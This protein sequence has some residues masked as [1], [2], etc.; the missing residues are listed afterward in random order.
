[1]PKL[2][3]PAIYDDAHHVESYWAA[4]AGPEVP[5]WAPL[6]GDHACDVAVVG[7]GY[8]GLACALHLARD[9]GIDARV[10]EAGPPGWGASGRNGGFCSP[11]ASKLS[12]ETM[13]ARYG[14]EATRRYFEAGKESVELVR[15][16]ARAEAI[17]IDARGDGLIAV[18]HRPSRIDGLRQEQAFL[19]D[20]FGQKT[21]LWS[22]EELAEHAYRGPEAFGGLHLPVGFGLHPL[23][24]ARG[25]AHAALKHG[26]T[27]HGNSRVIAWERNG[28]DHILR[29]SKGSLRARRVVMAANG[30]CRDDLDRRFRGTF[31]PALSN[32]IVTRPLTRDELAAQAW[33]TETPIY[34]TRNL[35]FSYRML[36]DKRFLLGGRGGTDASP[37]GAA[38]MRRWMTKR[39]GEMWPAW[40]DV[41]VSHFWRGF[42]CLAPDLL[43]HLGRLPDDESVFY[44][45]AY[46]G[47][48]VAMASWCGR[49]LARAIADDLD[50]ENIPA[51]ITQPLRR[52]PL[53]AFRVWYLRGAYALYRAKD[54]WL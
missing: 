26:A 22:R 7:G 49:A 14:L 1:V 37:E 44:S 42:V 30:F 52:Y 18:A 34:C 29:T 50:W 13:I 28:E 54:Q 8:T 31:L 46:H 19:A 11:G 21:T 25:L 41:E 45:F 5:G 20:V 40:K 51:V 15:E 17:E 32:I 38:R 48:G 33:R 2:Y 4:S 35:L 36:P 10:L 16:L 27:I 23:K 24:Y 9:F 6:E 47:N 53:A 39:L 43:P 3:H 12:D